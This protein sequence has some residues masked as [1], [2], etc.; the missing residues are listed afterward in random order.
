MHGLQREQLGESKVAI[1]LAA[2]RSN[3]FRKQ[4]NAERPEEFIANN[5]ECHA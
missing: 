5:F 4:D 2:F 1:S 3:Q